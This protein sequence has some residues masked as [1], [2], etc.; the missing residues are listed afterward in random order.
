MPLSGKDDQDGNAGCTQA[1]SL[2]EV[3]LQI[4][5]DVKPLVMC[6]TANKMGVQGDHKEGLEKEASQGKV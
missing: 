2:C 3:E 6:C 4:V 1:R 5:K